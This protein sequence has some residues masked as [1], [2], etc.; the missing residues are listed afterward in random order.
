[1]V[2]TSRW[3][4]RQIRA[5]CFLSL[6]TLSTL[7]ECTF[8]GVVSECTLCRLNWGPTKNTILQSIVFTRDPLAWLLYPLFDPRLSCFSKSA[9]FSR[10]SRSFCC[11]GPKQQ[12][13]GCYLNAGGLGKGKIEWAILFKMATSMPEQTNGPRARFLQR[14]PVIPLSL[15]QQAETVLCQLVVRVPRWLNVA[16]I[17]QSPNFLG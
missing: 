5:W 3:Q 2:T 10:K 8:H 17:G 9:A 1:M 12:T 15:C 11:Q 16:Q 13:V 4:V 6:I 7:S 14:R